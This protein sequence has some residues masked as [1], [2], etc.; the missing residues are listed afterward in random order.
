[1]VLLGLFLK[2]SFINSTYEDMKEL[3]CNPARLNEVF[4][5]PDNIDIDVEALSAA[6]CDEHVNE[7]I[8]QLRTGLDISH[9]VTKVL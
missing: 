1:M 7:T 4:S 2:E 3:L 9:I 6:L 8:Q 5:F